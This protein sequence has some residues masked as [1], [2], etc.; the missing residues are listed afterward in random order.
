M[1]KH[2]LIINSLGKLKDYDVPLHNHSDAG[3]GDELP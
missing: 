3:A 1:S 2:M